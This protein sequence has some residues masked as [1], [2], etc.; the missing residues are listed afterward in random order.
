VVFAEGRKRRSVSQPL[1]LA[2]IAHC[3]DVDMK[4]VPDPMTT[5]VSALR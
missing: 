2:I 1:D 5:G 4:N 3:V